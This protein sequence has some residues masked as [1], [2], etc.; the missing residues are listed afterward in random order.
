[1]HTRT[2][3]AHLKRALTTPMLYVCIVL[4]AVMLLGTTFGNL[5]DSDCI[6]DLLTTAQSEFYMVLATV[7][8]ALAYAVTYVDDFDNKLLHHWTVRSGVRSYA[9][10]YYLVS[11]LAGFIVSFA[12]S[13]LFIGIMQLR[14]FSLDRNV[15]SN[16]SQT[17]FYTYSLWYFRGQMV[18]YVTAALSEYALGCAA[19]AGFAAACG[20][21]MH[22][23]LSSVVVPMI[24]FYI[25]RI[26][27]K[28]DDYIPPLKKLLQTG[29][30]KMLQDYQLVCQSHFAGSIVE[31]P[32][33]TL[34]Y[35]FLFVAA[36]A[37]IFGTITVWCI[38][39]SAENA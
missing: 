30:G 4:Y 15:V 18:P 6:A 32:L 1:M 33:H 16:I 26:I 28:L 11:I 7:F 24:Y 29:V 12:G 27:Y 36:Y 20:A 9:V 14:G 38:E 39:R 31:L 37:I 34:L 23:K 13:A 19:M 5:A 25:I 17:G 10:S 3:T 22:R 2:F 8:P 35:K 21:M